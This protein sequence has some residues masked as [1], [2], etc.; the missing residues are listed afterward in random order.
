[1]VDLHP[2]AR[3][4][5]HWVVTGIAPGLTSL[6]EGAAS[7]GMPA[8]SHELKPYAG[9][10]P[11]SGTHEYEFTLY[12]LDA[13]PSL[14]AK[15]TVAQFLEASESNILATARLTGAFTKLKA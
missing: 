8:G 6:E 7:T 9:P 13:E 4:Y 12:A 15:A 3:G 2:I 5:V 10:F 1:M 14:P 11:P